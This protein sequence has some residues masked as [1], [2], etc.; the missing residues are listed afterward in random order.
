MGWLLGAL[1]SASASR[2]VWVTPQRCSLRVAPHLKLVEDYYVSHEEYMALVGVWRAELELDD[3][4]ASLSLH[5][6][7]PPSVQ[8]GE[9]APGG[10]RVH[11][12]DD[13]LPFNICQGSDGSTSARWS[14]HSGGGDQLALSMQLGN[15]YLEGRGTRR[16]LRCAAFSGT[17]LEGGSDPCVVGRFSMR[18]ALP[19][20]S[21]TTELEERYRQR[22]A[23]RKAPPLAFRR[24]G[25][26]G[27]WRLLLTV[28]EDAVPAYF[29]VEL[30]E[31]GFWRS[32]GTEETL[33][34]SWGL[35]ARDGSG[36]TSV[37]DAGSSVW[38]KVQRERSS[39]TLRGIAGLPV[40]SDFHLSGKPVLGT[41]ERELAARAAYD[42]ADA[43][44]DGSMV[45]IVDR[46]DGRLWEGE[47]ERAYFGRFSLLRGDASQL[48]EDCDE[49]DDAA[50]EALSR[51]EEAKLAWLA[52]ADA[53]TLDEACDTGDGVAC[54]ALSREEEAKRAWLAKLA[55]PVVARACEN[56]DDVACETALSREEEAKRAWLAK[57]HSPTWQGNAPASG[58]SAT[59][60]AAP[61]REEPSWQADAPSRE[62]QAKREWLAKLDAPTW[63]GTRGTH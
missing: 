57:L 11:P 43:A 26:V 55:T 15:L 20:T 37:V 40:R 27:R 38:L 56:G 1:L 62:E 41:A 3:G 53:P 60:R 12:M 10:G 50:C 18:L 42:S 16:G 61:P 5:L 35:N 63:R 31:D 2:R 17:V 30:F 39:E 59:K 28:D 4:D 54:E 8:P 6:A 36:W 25:F 24:A 13:A 32:V 22:L 48:V 49:G 33:G 47:V 52:K 14:A 58:Q 44:T 19:I 45:D 46:V 7:A 23:A 51:E 21:D 34:G 29:P 9:V